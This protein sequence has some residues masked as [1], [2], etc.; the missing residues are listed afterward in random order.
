MDKP[1]E[2]TT[3]EY[4]KSLKNSESFYKDTYANIAFKQ[5]NFKEA[6]S[7]QEEAIQGEYTNAEMRE[8]YLKFVLASENYKKAQAK[9]EEFIKENQG[10]EKIK[11]DLKLAYVKN[12]GSEDGFEEYLIS[13]EETGHE[14]AIADS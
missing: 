12:I 5:G 13:L 14:K 2:M 10:S 7:Y 1:T 11:E 9:A 3:T 4:A 8:S 6:I